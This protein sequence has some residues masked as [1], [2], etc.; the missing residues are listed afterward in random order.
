MEILSPFT[1]E[2]RTGN[3]PIQAALSLIE[4]PAMS[5]LALHSISPVTPAAVRSFY[6]GLVTARFYESWDFYTTHLGFRTVQENDTYVHLQ[7][8]TGCQ[9]AL[10]QHETASDVPE[11]VSAT[12]GRGFWLG[13]KVEDADEMHARLVAAGVPIVTAPENKPWGERHFVVR[14]PNGVLIYVAHPLKTPVQA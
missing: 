6:P 11:L 8:P 13:L 4:P 7:H 1:G 14:D 12:D 3:V 9:L 10:L 5:T 2:K